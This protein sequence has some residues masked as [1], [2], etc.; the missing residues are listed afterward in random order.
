MALRAWDGAVS[1]EKPAAALLAEQPR[2]VLEA[3]ILDRLRGARQV[4][5]HVKKQRALL[6]LQD[7]ETTRDEPPPPAP[8]ATQVS[9]KMRRRI[10]SARTRWADAFFRTEMDAL[11]RAALPELEGTVL[12]LQLLP[13]TLAALELLDSCGRR[14]THPYG[15][16]PG[17]WLAANLEDDENLDHHVQNLSELSLLYSAPDRSVLLSCSD[18]GRHISLQ[19]LAQGGAAGARVA[20]HHDIATDG[21]D[22]GAAA[23]FVHPALRRSSAWPN[24][25]ASLGDVCWTADLLGERNLPK[26]RNLCLAGAFFILSHRDAANTSDSCQTDRFHATIRY[27]FYPHAAQL[28]ALCLVGRRYGI[29]DDLVQRIG[30]AMMHSVVHRVA[31]SRLSPRVP[32][33]LT[34]AS[35]AAAGTSS[36]AVSS[37]GLANGVRAVVF[38]PPVVLRGLIEAF[39]TGSEVGSYSRQYHYWRY[40]QIIISRRRL[41]NGE[42]DESPSPRF[43]LTI[44]FHAHPNVP[45]HPTCAAKAELTF[46]ALNCETSDASIDRAGKHPSIWVGS[47]LIDP[48]GLI[49]TYD[50]CESAGREGM[51]GGLFS[52]LHRV[53]TYAQALVDLRAGVRLELHADPTESESTRVVLVAEAT[54]GGVVRAE[55][56]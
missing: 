41:V 27:L 18:D 16:T 56:F 47:D 30:G 10:G 26:Q 4:H 29:G 46:K 54:K 28:Q 55:A 33:L 53:G 43:R 24:G 17:A 49:G 13:S 31:P 7:A 11:R 2:E 32:H 20:Y 12:C 15:S 51:E 45:P 52:V 8:P 37:A 34:E 44:G 21:T 22:G 48:V 1:G 19:R 39:A 23:V 14:H 5:W 35:S 25:A 6:S 9:K 40:L 38:I 50:G 36:S 42:E 3:I